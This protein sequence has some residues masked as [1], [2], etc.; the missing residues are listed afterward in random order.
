MTI[1]IEYNGES[2]K[3][4]FTRDSIKRMEDR[5]FDFSKAEQKQIS[6]L[7]E[8][9]EGAFRTFTPRITTDKIMEVWGALKGKDELYK[10]LMEM[11]QEPLKVLNEPDEDSEGNASWK[12]VK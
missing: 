1:T 2:Y 9:V 5:G 8:L 3:L 11:F 6:S 12:I 7:F 4:G 10:A